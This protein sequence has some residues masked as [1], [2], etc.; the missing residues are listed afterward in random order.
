M[1]PTGLPA[2]VLWAA[3][4]IGIGCGLTLEIIVYYF[5]T[6]TLTRTQREV[7]VSNRDI[8]PRALWWS[9]FLNL[10]PLL[11]PLWEIFVVLKLSSSIRK[12]FAERG[13]NT[14]SE[15]FGRTV[16][17]IWA[18][19]GLLYMPIAILQ[20]YLFL[21][22]DVSTAV[23]LSAIE[24]PISMLLLICFVLFWIQIAQYG[25]RFRAG[26]LIEAKRAESRGA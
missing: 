4:G 11:G 19:G 16:G 25:T 21:N 1:N 2:E 14:K 9:V 10:I 15:G 7:N 23:M 20:M 24:T 8:S 3:I 6:R 5:F 12:E 13:W 26:Q 17:L 22:G 18:L